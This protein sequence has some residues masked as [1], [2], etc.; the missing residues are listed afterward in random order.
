MKSALPI[1]ALR[2]LFESHQVKLA[3]LFG[4]QAHGTAGPLSDI[5]LAIVFDRNLSIQD[6]KQKLETLNQALSTLLKTDHIDLVNLASTTDP[7]L[8]HRAVFSGQC[9]YAPNRQARFQLERA[10][11]QDYEDTRSLRTTQYRLMQQRL[12]A[13]TFG[14]AVRASPYIQKILH[15][16]VAN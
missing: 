14:S 12:T 9:L 10:I 1:N 7:L 4:S 6:Q 8:K 3:Y 2:T 13:D 5:D 11:M 16:H 15:T